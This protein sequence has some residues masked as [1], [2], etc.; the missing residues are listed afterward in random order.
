[1]NAQQKAKYLKEKEGVKYFTL[2]FENRIFDVISK[3]DYH[4]SRA[5]QSWQHMLPKQYYLMFEAHQR[6]QRLFIKVEV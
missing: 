1:M 3:I 6:I 4:S 2:K 5:C